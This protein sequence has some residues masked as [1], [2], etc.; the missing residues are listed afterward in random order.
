MRKVIGLSGLKGAGKDTC[1]AYLT[2]ALGFV[3]VGFA[4]TLY[5][6]AAEAFGVTVEFMANRET[7]ETPLPQLAL[8]N[9]KDPAFVQ[10]VIEEIHLDSGAFIGDAY[11]DHPLSPRVVMQ[12]WGTE[13]RRKRGVDSYWL[14]IV[15]AAIQAQPEKSFVI[16]DVR[17]LN[18]FNF[19]RRTGGVNVRVRRP[20][21]EAAEALQRAKNGTAAHSSE[22]ELL[23]IKSDAE[24]VNE[25]GNPDS[26]RESI[27]ALAVG[28]AAT[29]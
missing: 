20:A 9:C 17:F 29:A 11:L 25:E 23:A 2:S 10:C 1:A 6:Q 21:L 16:T 15:H 28:E 5:R 22:T 12:L 8:R 24:V 18:E 19:V 4:D 26:L 14:D 7:K 27:I 13:Y 3:R